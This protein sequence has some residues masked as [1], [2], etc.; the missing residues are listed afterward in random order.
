MKDFDHGSDMPF[1]LFLS[2]VVAAALPQTVTPTGLVVPN[3]CHVQFE[4]L[5]EM[6][7]EEA[8]SRSTLSHS[9]M[10]KA[11][12][13]ALTEEIACI[14][15]K[16]EQD[17]SQ[18][19]KDPD[20]KKFQDCLTKIHIPPTLPSVYSDLVSPLSQ[21]TSNPRRWYVWLQ[22]STMPSRKVY[23]LI[24]I[25]IYGILSYQRRE[26]SAEHNK[27]ILSFLKSIILNSIDLPDFV[28]DEMIESDA[29]SWSKDTADPPMLSVFARGLICA[30][31]LLFAI[32]LCC[33]S[34]KDNL[35]EVKT[36]LLERVHQNVSDENKKELI[37]FNEF[38]KTQ[39]AQVFIAQPYSLPEERKKPLDQKFIPPES[40]PWSD[41]STLAPIRARI[42]APPAGGKTTL[43]RNL[44]AAL[45]RNSLPRSKIDA[46]NTLAKQLKLGEASGW[47]VIGL[48]AQQY[49]WYREEYGVDR[50]GNFV[51]MFFRGNMVHNKV[52]PN[53]VNTAMQTL[54]PSKLRNAEHMHRLI[55]MFDGYD[56][57]INEKVQADFKK[58]MHTFLGSYPS[59]HVL[60]FTRPI[61]REDRAWFNRYKFQTHIISPQDDTQRGAFVRASSKDLSYD[62]YAD[63]AANPLM[64][65]LLLTENSNSLFTLACNFL[66]QVIM[67]EYDCQGRRMYLPGN[68]DKE[69]IF[70]ILAQM[71]W[72][73]LLNPR[74]SIMQHLGKVL[75]GDTGS[76][77]T[78]SPIS[79]KEKLIHTFACQTGVLEYLVEWADYRFTAPH[80]QAVLAVSHILRILKLNVD[81]NGI[82]YALRQL[83]DGQFE[84]IGFALVHAQQYMDATVAEM[85]FI[86]YL[87]RVQENP[88]PGRRILQDIQAI[89]DGIYGDTVI[90]RDQIGTCSQLFAVTQAKLNLHSEI[91]NTL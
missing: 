76:A 56:E 1:H 46:A 2:T 40:M 6:I 78:V 73:T 17:F 42:E 68:I 69:D 8:Y 7:Q 55:F 43:Y 12:H 19:K 53:V 80:V 91:C 11:I 88:E 22:G 35:K 90:Q 27:R 18:R 79:E 83:P 77:D 25:L 23:E 26:T 59:A 16:L 24:L 67:K 38:R 60:I 20:Y 41:L 54:I 64:L 37:Y 57:L 4:A 5:C 10:F 74:F 9:S 30:T 32:Y 34:E 65:R 45:V 81:P 86:D 14:N 58:A 48:N 44:G 3:R 39:S 31:F 89:Q 29:F 66:H 85:M 62:R 51:E 15:A 70:W 33:D 28:C 71:A 87:S 50:C 21:Y 75:G 63:A 36:V 52:D 47:L 61:R 82:R 72:N 84:D 13:N 49:L